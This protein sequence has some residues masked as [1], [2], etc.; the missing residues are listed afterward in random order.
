MIEL[1][2]TDYNKKATS[3]HYYFG[4]AVL[5]EH[6][7]QGIHL[8]IVVLLTVMVYL[9]MVLHWMFPQIRFYLIYD[10][11]CVAGSGTERAGC[12]CFLHSC[13][14]F[15]FFIELVVV[16]LAL[17]K[18]HSKVMRGKAL[19]FVRYNNSKTYTITAT[20]RPPITVPSRF[21]PSSN[22]EKCLP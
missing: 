22:Q 12:L 20:T 2:C 19:F 1:L 5:V 15:S 21:N 18:I 4:N 10:F 17:K 14:H 8:I 11:G 3:I 13:H 9:T 6:L 7:Q 16:I